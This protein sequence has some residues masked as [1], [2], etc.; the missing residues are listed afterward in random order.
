MKY[1]LLLIL[2]SFSQNALAEDCSCLQ[3]EIISEECSEF[4]YTNE[5]AKCDEPD[6]YEVK[7]QEIEARLRKL[8]LQKRKIKQL[9][10]KPGNLKLDQRHSQNRK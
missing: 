3:D 7:F 2:L 1:L 9:G 5:G 6:P 4:T 8:E 10:S